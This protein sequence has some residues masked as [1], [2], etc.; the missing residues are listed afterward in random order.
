[1]HLEHACT[2]FRYFLAELGGAGGLAVNLHPS[3][4]GG[5]FALSERNGLMTSTDVPVLH[6]PSGAP[7]PGRRLPAR[8]VRV[9]S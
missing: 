9:T 4:G 3:V 7:V 1:M 8:S 6:A 5:A 2:R